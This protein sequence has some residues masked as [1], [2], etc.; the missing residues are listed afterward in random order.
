MTSSRRYAANRH[1][2]A[3]AVLV[4]TAIAV[5]RDPIKMTRA[6]Q[7]AV[8]ASLEAYEIGLAPRRSGSNESV[9]G[10][11]GEVSECKYETLYCL[12]VV[13]PPCFNYLRSCN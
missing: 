11:F 5:A 4:N 10:V 6:F 2:C 13:S 1:E 8:E 9:D 7:K 12:S 3:D